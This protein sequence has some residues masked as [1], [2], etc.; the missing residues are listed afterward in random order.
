MEARFKLVSS[1]D[2]HPG[3]VQTMGRGNFSQTRNMAPNA[4]IEAL[5][6]IKNGFL[7]DIIRFS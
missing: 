3:G 5:M 4:R 7:T 2:A 1:E 6:T